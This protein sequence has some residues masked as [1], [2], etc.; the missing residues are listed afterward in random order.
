M[1]RGLT[2]ETK[3][4]TGDL[5]QTTPAGSRRLARHVG[6]G[7]LLATILGMVLWLE[8][9]MYGRLTELEAA[10]AWL[11]SGRLAGAAQ[12]RAS[13][14]RMNEKLFRF[15]LT[16]EVTQREAFHQETRRFAESLVQAR[17]LLR[18]GDAAARAD[19]VGVAFEQFLADVVELTERGVRT[20]RRDTPAEVARL[21][22]EKS[23][24]LEESVDRLAELVNMGYGDR[25]AEGQRAFGRLRRTLIGSGIAMVVLLGVA[26][27]QIYRGLMAPLQ[28]EL[29]QAQAAF[30]RQEQLAALGVM[31]A[32][33]AHEIRNPLTA[34]KF[35]L[36]SLRKA[37]PAALVDHPDLSILG[38]EINR[39]ERIVQDFL[40]FARPT[41]P[42]CALVAAAAL[43]EEV[44]EL[45]RND[46]ER[47]GI[48]VRLETNAVI[49]VWADRPQL[50][51]ILI[52]L[53]RNAA[54]SMTAGG[55]LTLGVREG[56]ASWLR[57]TQAM[58]LLEVGDTGAGIPPEIEPRIFDPFYSTKEG[59]SGLGL[60]IAARIAELHGGH[61][62]YTTR[63]GQGTTFT[64]VLPKPTLHERENTVDRG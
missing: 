39:L 31:A 36:F 22:E 28:A 40:E 64:V 51:Q 8:V 7:L 2:T 38:K 23:R 20:M 57:R 13:V 52:N 46:L 34:L 17:T 9:S 61:I 16:E 60:S 6:A 27:F 59:G 5:R 1:E 56:A 21:I 42:R 41:E 62:Q 48:G 10:W 33:V 58:V 25:I 50:K 24:A 44:H 54:E 45:L 11:G 26:G 37:L 49:E 32:G 47:R 35:R 53:V 18:G 4:A 14:S 63:A 29:S 30:V 12:L 19:A 55:V 3:S 15:Q 43:V